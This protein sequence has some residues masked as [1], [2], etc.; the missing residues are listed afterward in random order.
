[1]DSK[2]GGGV[3]REL[4]FRKKIWFRAGNAGRAGV[5]VKIRCFKCLVG[6]SESSG[7]LMALAATDP[8]YRFR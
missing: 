4:V 8:D 3:R 5:L 1:M 2:E 7:S 6:R